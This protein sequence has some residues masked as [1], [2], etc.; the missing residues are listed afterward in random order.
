MRGNLQAQGRVQDWR[1]VLH[2]GTQGLRPVGGACQAGAA[3]TLF[4]ALRTSFGAVQGSHSVAAAT[5]AVVDI[6][7]RTAG[8][9]AAAQSVA[10][11]I[12]K[13]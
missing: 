1:S 6:A 4:A 11:D 2:S 9:I 13:Q 10:G 8:R 3:D 5:E 12:A 7:G